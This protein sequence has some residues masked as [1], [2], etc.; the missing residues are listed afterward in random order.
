[1]STSRYALA[2]L[3]LSFAAAMPSHAVV[4]GQLETFSSSNGGWFIGGGPGGAPIVPLPVELTGGPGGSGDAFLHVTSTGTGG[5]GSRLVANNAGPWTGNYLGA[6]ITHIAMD[7]K[8]LGAVDLAVR[9]FFEDPIPLPPQN[10]AHTSFVA[11][12]AAGSGWTRFVFP[13]SPRHLVADLGDAASVLSNTTF[14]RIY[15]SASG[16]FPGEP[17]AASLGIDNI[18]A[19]V[20]EPAT[21]AL[22]LAGLGLVGVVAHRRA[23]RRTQR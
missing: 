22:M 15:H 18:Q 13:I 5:A 8:N 23:A 2:A 16:D 12:L 19:A 6:G 1:M 4:L 17:I 3:S 10:E 9:L 20:P 11:H 7:L 14:F 21:T